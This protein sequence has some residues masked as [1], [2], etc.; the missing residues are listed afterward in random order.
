M[1]FSNSHKP[2]SRKSSLPH[3][4]DREYAGPTSECLDLSVD[5]LTE[6][7]KHFDNYRVFLKRNLTPLA[8]PLDLL[9]NIEARL[10]AIDAEKA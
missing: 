4:A 2:Q 5:P 9:A 7:I 10:A 1:S 8:A 3:I 6:E